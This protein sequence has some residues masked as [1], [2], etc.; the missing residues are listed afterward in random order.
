MPKP[1]LPQIGTTLVCN[2]CGHAE[3]NVRW[4]LFEDYPARK[5]VKCGSDSICSV[6]RG[7]VQRAAFCFSYDDKDEE[8]KLLAAEYDG[9]EFAYK[10]F[11]GLANPSFACLVNWSVC[12]GI[13]LFDFCSNKL[14]LP[15][16]I[17]PHKFLTKDISSL[18]DWYQI[19]DKIGRWLDARSQGLIEE[20]RYN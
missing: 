7:G 11:K 12:S 8:W 16:G 2:E 9:S 1:K 19:V 15:V 13:S 17:D 14:R 4:E 3:F 5:C 10:A 20:G 18:R 6:V